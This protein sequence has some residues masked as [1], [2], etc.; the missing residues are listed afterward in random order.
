[1]HLVVCFFLIFPKQ[2]TVGF[3]LKKK[4]VCTGLRA[5]AQLGVASAWRGRAWLGRGVGV[6]WAWRG[7]GLGVAWAWC[8]RGLGEGVAWAWCGRG[9]GWRGRGLGAAWAW[10]GRGRGVG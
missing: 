7:R 9:L 10:R 1:M 3:T 5:P 2:F 6:A 8:G 4:E